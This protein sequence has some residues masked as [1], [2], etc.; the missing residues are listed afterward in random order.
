MMKYTKRVVK[1]VTDAVIAMYEN[2]VYHDNGA[3]SFV[4]WCEDGNL[5]FNMR[6]D[7]PSIT[8]TDVEKATEMMNEVAPLVDDLTF[9]F[10]NT[11]NLYDEDEEVDGMK[12]NGELSEKYNLNIYNS[13]NPQFPYFVREWDECFTEEEIME[14][15]KD[16]WMTDNL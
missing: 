9:R 2:N 12:R 3:E 14:N 5:F 8:E 7:N 16:K 4:G 10:L 6:E 15:L 1:M 11:D 13:F